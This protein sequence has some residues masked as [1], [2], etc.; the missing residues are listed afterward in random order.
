LDSQKL[1]AELLE[2]I[3][4]WHSQILNL[5][6]MVEQAYFRVDECD[7]QIEKEESAA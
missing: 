1:K 3:K 4:E 6:R 5:E 7:E 2:Q